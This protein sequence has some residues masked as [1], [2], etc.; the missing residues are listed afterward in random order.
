MDG[1]YSSLDLLKLL[2]FAKENTHLTDAELIL[3]FTK[4]H[5][6]KTAKAELLE[7][8]DKIPL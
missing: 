6:R 3:K 1:K 5:P 4:N 2:K 8:L 7:I